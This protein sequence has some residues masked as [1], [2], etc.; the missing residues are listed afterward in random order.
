M[1]IND[2]RIFK[3]VATRG[4]V[5]QAALDLNYVQSNVTA[6]I[7]QLEAE[8]QT[9][10]FVRHKRGMILNSEGKRLMEYAEEILTKFNEIQYAFQNTEDPRGILN[11]GIVDTMTN[12]PGILSPYIDRYPRVEF[13]LHAGVSQNLFQDVLNSRLDGAFMTGP[14]NHPLIETH[15]VFDE[16][17]IIVSKSDQ[18]VI[19]DA[20]TIPFL[21]FNQGCG[22]RERLESW[23]RSEGIMPRKVMSF[24]TFETIMGSVAAGI[25]ITIA[26]K[27][28]TRTWIDAGL[29]YGYDIPEEFNK[30]STVFIRRNDIYYTNTLQSFVQTLP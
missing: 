17:L 27:S 21:L 3:T 4:S 8:L 26:P 13:S 15:H 22:Y 18:F 23:L 30:I 24:G 25:G 14:V 16:E 6:R 5:S 9:A 1:D 19:E 11:I 28:S 12:L 10:L 2:L 29:L 20:S 7:K